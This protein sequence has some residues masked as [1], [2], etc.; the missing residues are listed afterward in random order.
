VEPKLECLVRL[1]LQ[2][3]FLA[4]VVTKHRNRSNN[5]QQQDL[6]LD[7][8]EEEVYLEIQNQKLV[9]A[10]RKTLDR[11]PINKLL[12]YLVKLCQLLL[13]TDCFQ[14]TQQK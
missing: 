9:E 3:D 7:Q 14:G 5:L 8:V 13:R 6:Y 4:L 11:Q 2:V 12:L 1:V 10:F